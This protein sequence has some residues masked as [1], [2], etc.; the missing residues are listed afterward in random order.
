MANMEESIEL[1]E[2]VLTKNIHTRREVTVSLCKHGD[3]KIK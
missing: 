3:K 2:N 1:C